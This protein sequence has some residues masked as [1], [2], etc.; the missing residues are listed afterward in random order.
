MTVDWWTA[1]LIAACGVLGVWHARVE[2]WRATER[3]EAALRGERKMHVEIEGKLLTWRNEIIVDFQAQN[4]IL[5]DCQRENAELR[6]RL[7]MLARL[8]GQHCQ[9]VTIQGEEAP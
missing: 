8:E 4:A 3:Y 6:R 1:A 9:L 7:S 5:T 2:R